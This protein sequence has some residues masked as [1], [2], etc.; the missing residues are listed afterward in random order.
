M[1]CDPIIRRKEK[2]TQKTL[3]LIFTLLGDIVEN[4]KSDSLQTA[5][6]YQ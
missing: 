5:A 2:K 6:L 1:R 4:P 3:N